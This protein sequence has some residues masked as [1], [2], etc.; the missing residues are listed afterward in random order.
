MLL[1]RVLK[2]CSI[3]NTVQHTGSRVQGVYTD[4]MAVLEP[5]LYSS[6]DIRVSRINLEVH[7]RIVPINGIRGLDANLDWT[8]RVR[9]RDFWDV[10]WVALAAFAVL[11][12]ML[13][14]FGM[15]GGSGWAGLIPL[16]IASL[17]LGLWFRSANPTDT[18]RELVG[19]QFRAEL[20][21]GTHMEFLV[22][23]ANVARQIAAALYRATGIWAGGPEMWSGSD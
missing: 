3:K 19:Y 13:A 5:D 11:G 22:A 9:R 20:K 16:L 14:G 4:L 2:R 6:E 1:E 7:G 8:E 15:R 23:D 17:L 12:T 10:F 21:D 18:Q